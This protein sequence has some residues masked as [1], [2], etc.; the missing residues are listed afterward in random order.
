ML[1]YARQAQSGRMHWSQVSGD[2]HYPEHPTDPSE[3]LANV[4]TAKDASTALDSYNPPQKLYQRTEGEARRTARPG[5]W[6]GGHRSRDG[7]ALKYMPAA[8]QEAA[9]GRDGRSA[10]AAA[11]RQARHHRERRRYSLRRQGRRGRAQVP[12]KRR[13]EGHRRARRPDRQG[14]QQPEARQADRHRGRQHGALALAAARPRRA[15][16]RRRLCH[17]QHPRLYAEGDAARRAGLDHQGGDREA[18]HSRH[19]A[20]DRDHE[21]HHGQS[22]LE[23]AAVDRLRRISAGAAAGPDRA[24]ADGIEARAQPRRQHPHFAAARRSQRA[25]PHPLQ[26]P[27]QV[28][29]LSA[30]HPGQISVRQG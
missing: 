20:A 28:P 10:R 12:G 5:R 26:L 30:R 17:P 8:R 9:G 7:P 25:R 15:L 3:V 24:A 6:P 1:D 13:T 14:H 29:G 27:E 18:G 2:I 16:D 19:A 11:A 22:D 21:V 23:R 4:T